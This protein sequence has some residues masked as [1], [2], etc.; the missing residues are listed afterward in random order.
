ME[1]YK[2]NNQDSIINNTMHMT[3]NY[4]HEKSYIS[5]QCIKKKKRFSESSLNNQKFNSL[6]TNIK[7]NLL[8]PNIA[9]G[10]IFTKS[11]YDV[12]GNGIIRYEQTNHYNIRR[13]SQQPQSKKGKII[14]TIYYKSIILICDLLNIK[15]QIRIHQPLKYSM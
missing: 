11:R 12:I 2:I 8:P 9:S 10:Q 7:P 14:Y 3:A 1:V 15:V 4:I 13:L 5:S 6:L